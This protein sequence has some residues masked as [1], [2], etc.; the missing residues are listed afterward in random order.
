MPKSSVTRA[1][2][3]EHRS[4]ADQTAESIARSRYSSHPVCPW[5]TG[6]RL[7]SGLHCLGTVAG[8]AW[9]RRRD[10]ESTGLHRLWRGIP[11]SELFRLGRRR[12]SRRDGRGRC[13]PR[14]RRIRLP[15]G[16]VSPDG[17]TA[18]I[19]PNGRSLKRTGSRLPYPVPVCSTS[20]LNS[21]PRIGPEGDEW[22]FSTPWEHPERFAKSSPV[23]YI[24][25]AR[26]P[27]LILQGENDKIDPMGQSTALYR[28][29]KRY[30]V[31]TELVLYPQR[32]PRTARGKASA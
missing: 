1:L 6:R 8:G 22:Y 21:E 2:T 31:E 27:T 16:S 15:T 25:N 7:S 17:P 13:R 18:A 30:N 23:T 29:L 19:W 9:L 14:A 3:A 4:G 26:T 5:R 12:L 32:T 20:A 24:K 28:A 11:E 10:A